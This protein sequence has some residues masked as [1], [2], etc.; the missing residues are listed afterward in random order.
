MK[1]YQEVEI[2]V[3]QIEEDVVRTSPVVESTAEK[4][5]PWDD[6]IFNFGA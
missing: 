4:N 6:L 2:E 5:N 1:T 3:L